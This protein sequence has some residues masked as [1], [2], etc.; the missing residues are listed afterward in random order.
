M[1]EQEI[2]SHG[3]ARRNAIRQMQAWLHRVNPVGHQAL[4]AALLDADLRG[5]DHGYQV[6]E[7]A[8]LRVWLEDRDQPLPPERQ[9]SAELAQAVA[10][11][12]DRP[13]HTWRRAHALQ[14]DRAEQDQDLDHL[15]GLWREHRD[16]PVLPDEVTQHIEALS[17]SREAR[18][19][20]AKTWMRE[21]NP[22]GYAD[23]SRRRGF[24]DT[25]GDECADDRALLRD[26][27]DRAPAHTVDGHPQTPRERPQNSRPAPAR[28]A[29]A[30]SGARFAEPTCEEPQGPVLGR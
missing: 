20:A 28:E 29:S 5:N 2:P 14:L 10:W 21:N 12:G 9:R 24:A 18:L 19:D 30:L 8:A 17:R 27:N 15:I 4:N 23:W 13:S 11:L 1:S 7:D 26:W 16:A 3:T 22:S 6:L 25:L